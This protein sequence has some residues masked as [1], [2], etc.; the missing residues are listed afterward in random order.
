MSGINSTTISAPALCALLKRLRRQDGGRLELDV[1]RFRIGVGTS[2]LISPADT[3]SDR[4]RNSVF[5]LAALGSTRPFEKRKLARKPQ[6]TEIEYLTLI[7][8]IMML[9][10]ICKPDLL[11]RSGISR[12]I[13]QWTAILQ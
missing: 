2:W 7:P 3:V 12:A 4:R 1:A 5:S 10:L 6:D 9:L 8:S 13:S 11:K